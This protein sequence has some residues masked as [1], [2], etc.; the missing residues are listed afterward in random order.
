MV[1]TMWQ[2]RDEHQVPTAVCHSPP[3]TAGNIHRLAADTLVTIACCSL[4]PAGVYL[5]NHGHHKL[6][7]VLPQ[8]GHHPLCLLSADSGCQ[9]PQIWK[10]AWHSRLPQAWQRHEQ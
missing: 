1:P 9:L 10:L 5:V 8:L 4:L 3:I 2:C 6:L 7:R